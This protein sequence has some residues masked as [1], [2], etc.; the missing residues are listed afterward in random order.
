MG[1]KKFSLDELKATFRSYTLDSEIVFAVNPD[2]E[3]EN[4][5]AAF[6]LAKYDDGTFTVI[7]KTVVPPASHH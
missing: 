6:A 3:M 5:L 1:R 2:P 4:R 7:A